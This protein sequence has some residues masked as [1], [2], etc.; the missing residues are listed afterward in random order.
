MGG[1]AGETGRE[2]YGAG[3]GWGKSGRSGLALVQRP[4]DFLPEAKR[5]MDPSVRWDDAGFGIAEDFGY[6]NCS[7]A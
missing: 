5:Q 3:W 1:V 4:G 6:S 7:R 2:F